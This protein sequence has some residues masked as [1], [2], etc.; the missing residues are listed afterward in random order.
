MGSAKRV[1]EIDDP[2]SGGPMASWAVPKAPSLDP[3]VR[4]LAIEVEDH[5]YYYSYFEG[6]I[7][8]GYGKGDVVLWDDGWWEPDPDEMARLPC[9]L[10]RATPS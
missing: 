3:G 6:V 4:S 8:D 1:G 7:V 10:H 2:S 9:G 5:P